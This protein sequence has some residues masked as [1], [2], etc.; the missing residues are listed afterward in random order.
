MLYL[1]CEP[2]KNIKESGADADAIT[3]ES[4][5]QAQAWTTLPSLMQQNEG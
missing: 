1:F 2:Q 3:L 4:L 5:L